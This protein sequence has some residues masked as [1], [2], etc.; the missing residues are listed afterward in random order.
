MLNVFLSAP[1]LSLTN[2]HGSLSPGQN[3]LQVTG[4]G[5]DV[6]GQNN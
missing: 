1:T 2:V 5:S 3:S 4:W 6:Q